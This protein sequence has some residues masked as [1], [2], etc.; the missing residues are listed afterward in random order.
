MVSKVI[1]F[2]VAGSPVAEGIVVGVVLV[3]AVSH[4]GW[5]LLAKA[6][7]DQVVAFW[8]INLASAVCGAGIL[9]A[10]GGPA[11][12]A[13]VYL[14]VSAF[15]HVGYN[16]SLLNSYRFG[17]LG[18]VYPLA[19]GIAPLL[20]TGGAAAAAGEGLTTWQL[21][22]VAVVAGGLTSLVWL[23]GH[24]RIR[25]RRA[26]A[27]AVATG[28]MIAA[29]SLTD[30]LGVRHAHNPLGYAGALFVVESSVLVIALASWRRRLLPARLDRTWAL[31]IAGGVLSVA[32]YTAVL[33]AQTRLALGV[34]SSLRE[35][36]VV[37]AALLGTFF[38]HEG[39]GRRRLLAA[40]VVCVGVALLVGA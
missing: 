20:V 9:A 36:S 35:T 5:N 12:A 16:L 24:G 22:G 6:V 8:L 15:I 10:V 33:W 18:Q 3:A 1:G 23:G 32:T 29:Y 30:G 4:A 2:A 19:R 17:D 39:S 13:W 14:V 38:L 28:V 31:G 27:L 11:R 40:T 7:H 25:D 37:V 21:I 34:V 26:V